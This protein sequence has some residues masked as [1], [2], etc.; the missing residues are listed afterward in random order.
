M[1]EDISYFGEVRGEKEK[2][3]LYRRGLIWGCLSRAV[4]LKVACI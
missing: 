2:P 4:V 3:A 1:I